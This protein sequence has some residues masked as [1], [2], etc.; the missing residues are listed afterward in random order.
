MLALRAFPLKIRGMPAEARVTSIWKLQRLFVALF[1]LGFAGFFFWDGKIGYP[2]SNERWIAYEQHKT[3]NRVSEWPA[4]AARRGWTDKVPE[5]FYKA[6]D[7]VMQYICGIISGI[8]GSF[9]LVYWV[10]N[11]GRVLKTAEGAVFEPSGKRIPFKSITGLGKKNWEKKGLAIVRY[12][13]D[14]R[15]GK[16]VLDDYKFEAEPTHQILAEIEEHLLSESPES[17][18]KPSTS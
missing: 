16:F 18:N 12:D 6:E 7:I 11:K 17:Q 15:Q 9:V 14:G 3:E 1:F 13:V 8:L 5:K 4:D 10:V 2:R